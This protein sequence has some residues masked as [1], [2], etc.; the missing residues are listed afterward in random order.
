MPRRSS[1]ARSSDRLSSSPSASNS[2]TSACTSAAESAR[3][4]G[5]GEAAGRDL[6]VHRAGLVVEG[7]PQA[8]RSRPRSRRRGSAPRAGAAPEA[9]AERGERDRQREDA[10]QRQA[11]GGE[12]HHRRQRPARRQARQDRR[13][14]RRSRGAAARPRAA[15][16]W[17]EVGEEPPGR[18]RCRPPPARRGRR[19]RRRRPRR[20]APRARPRR[21]RRTAGRRRRS[22]GRSRGRRA[23]A[24]GSRPSWNMKARVLRSASC[25]RLVAERGRRSPPSR[26]RRR[27][28]RRP[29]PPPRR[30][31]AWS[32]TRPIWVRPPWQ[33]MPVIS[34]F[35]AR[36][37]GDPARGAGLAV[38]AVVDELHLEPAGARRGVEHR[39][40]QPAGEVPGRLAAHGGVEREDQPP[41]A[42]ARPAARGRGPRR[43]TPRPRPPRAAPRL[44]LGRCRIAWSWTLSSRDDLAMP[45]AFASAARRAGGRNPL[46]AQNR[47]CYRP[48]TAN[49]RARS[50]VAQW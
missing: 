16:S 50:G 24:A 4:P 28:G 14:P 38:A 18:R 25:A 49:R 40:L 31:A 10:R 44:G 27:P 30:A 15:R 13:R 41:A 43:G 39:R 23:A 20:G 45:P 11:G 21:G 22:A 36:G 33:A 35:S 8:A 1:Q 32:S 37:V 46:D 42:C 19:R 6:A 2:A 17:P 3:E 5:A 48:R 7:H 26:R 29:A 34:R 12:Q 47:L 9:D